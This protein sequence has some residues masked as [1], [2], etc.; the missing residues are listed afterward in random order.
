MNKD[1]A[2]AL[3]ESLLDRMDA[4]EGKWR[5]GTISAL[6]RA[7]LEVALRELTRDDA[8]ASEMPMTGTDGQS[9]TAPVIP[10][11]TDAAPA[12]DPGPSDLPAAPLVSV[13]ETETPTR[14]TVLNKRVLDLSAPGD[15]DVILC[16]D[17]GTAMS[18]AFAMR[19]NNTPVELALGRRAGASGYPVESSIF[20][21]NEGVLYFGPQAV[22]R[23]MDAAESGR[24]RF[25]SLKSRL[26][27][28]IQA[29]IN[30]IPMGREINPTDIPVYEGEMITLYLAYLTD[31]ATSELESRQ[32][33]RYVLRR[34]ARPC[35]DSGRNEWAEKLLRKMLAQAQI[36]A[37]TFHGCWE[38]GIP[39]SEAKAAL[40]KLRE[41]DRLPD[42]LLDRS[43]PEPVAAAASLMLKDQAQREVF[44][45][46]DV[47]AGTTDF[48]LFLLQHNPYKEVCVVHGI[49]SSVQ[50]L[51]QAGDVVD[52]LLKRHICELAAIDPEENHYGKHVA[53]EL[54]SRI[55]MYKE[56]LFRD[57]ILEVT[58]AN[59]TVVTVELNAF[60][61]LQTMRNL[62][63]LL[64]TKVA[65]VLN[66]L[67]SMD[68]VHR[69]LILEIIH[70]EHLNVV[71]TGGGATL[72]MIEALAEGVVEV[73]GKK[74]MRKRTAAVP[75]WIREQYPQFSSQYSQLAVAI[76]GANSELPDMGGVFGQV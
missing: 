23:G 69:D 6:E 29:D 19:T 61:E 41:L 39:L 73:F 37:D 47:G 10:L 4:Q 32:V 30:H 68:P 42:F 2:R 27:M 26:S 60:L 43:V 49:P 22:R 38:S 11:P 8:A 57:H 14:L 28:G 50:Y 51:P 55:R 31:L 56:T 40:E 25:D 71:L 45:V 3:L 34:F 33:S 17:F 12:T 76:G 48:G 5:I 20:I 72:P 74:I 58:L 63:R 21:S 44:L 18:K 67:E 15:Q 64:E 36:L 7:A 54:Q 62:A 24:L 53:A 52:S 46:I 16:L 59:Q 66:S 9:V 75:A 35:W 70:R 65:S 1:T 13:S